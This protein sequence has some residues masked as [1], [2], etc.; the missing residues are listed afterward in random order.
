MEKQRWK[1]IGNIILK[2]ALWAFLSVAFVF[3]VW[4]I[5]YWKVGNDSFLPSPWAALKEVGGLLLDGVFWKAFFGTFGR[6]IL[7]F[8]I[9]FVLGVGLAL[10]AYTVAW[11]RKLMR[12]VTA[13]IRALPTLAITLCLLLL[14]LPSRAPVVVA[15]MAL[16]PMLYHSA[17]N[18]LDGVDGKLIET[19]NVYR[20]PM[21]KRILGLYLPTAAPYIL[22][23]SA[24]A[25]AFSLK[26]TVSAEILALTAKSLGSMMQQ[27]QMFEEMPTVFALTIISVFVA[28]VL[29]GGLSI[30]ARFVERRVQ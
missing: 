28:C 17:L 29:E 9:S 23:E 12:G 18:A 8:F 13:V 20:V 19:C 24:A 3:G 2:N 22:K 21:K 6:S 16:A 30:L 27:A 5:F 25:V 11:F 10:I 14:V 15:C 1:K 26:L 7:A 4:G